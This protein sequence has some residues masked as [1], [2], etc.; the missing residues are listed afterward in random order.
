LEP[1]Q[2]PELG[3]GVVGE[4]AAAAGAELGLPAGSLLVAAPGDAATTTEGVADDSERAYAYLGTSGW[5]AHR[6]VAGDG[7]PHRRMYLI[8]GVALV[9]I[10]AT[11]ITAAFALRPQPLTGD[12]AADAAWRQRGCSPRR[13]ALA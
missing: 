2:L 3:D 6:E 11:A 1:E 5:V 7:T 12:A 8:G 9:L 10:A 4:L 13:R